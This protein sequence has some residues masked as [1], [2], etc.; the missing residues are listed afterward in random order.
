VQLDIGEALAERRPARCRLLHVVL[1][2]DALA[3][4]ERRL[5]PRHI[6]RLRDG[7]QRHALGSRPASA[8]TS[9]I[10]ART[11]AR[12]AATSTLSIV[13]RSPLAAALGRQHGFETYSIGRPTRYPD[14]RRRLPTRF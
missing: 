9:R 1:A 8:A 11:L 3:R 13:I 12:L 6:L 5:D 10:V 14:M 2:E 7:D 4:P